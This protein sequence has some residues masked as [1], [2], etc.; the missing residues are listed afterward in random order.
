LSLPGVDSK[1]EDLEAAHLAAEAARSKDQSH[2]QATATP[3]EKA[4]SL[5]I[6]SDVIDEVHQPPKVQKSSSAR[7]VSS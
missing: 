2:N 3:V 6:F 4:K 1:R 5:A 7:Q